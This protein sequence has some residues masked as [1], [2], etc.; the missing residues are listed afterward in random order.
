MVLNSVSAHTRASFVPFQRSIITELDMRGA[1][2]LFEPFSANGL[3]ANSPVSSRSEELALITFVSR[4]LMNTLIESKRTLSDL[5][6]T[7]Q[8]LRRPRL[9][10]GAA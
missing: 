7:A 9:D 3:A 1:N 6:T 5:R 2:N 8:C 10:S 4:G